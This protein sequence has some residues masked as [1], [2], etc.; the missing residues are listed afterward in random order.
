MTKLTLNQIVAEIKEG[1]EYLIYMK[2]HKQVLIVDADDHTRRLY[3]VVSEYPVLL[4]EIE[5]D[6]DR[7]AARL[8]EGL[9]KVA[10][11]RDV[12]ET[13]SPEVVLEVQERLEHPGAMVKGSP[14]CFV[15][16]IGGKRGRPF[17]LSIRERE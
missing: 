11:L 4:E 15:L 9:D 10:L 2:E 17:E 8:A 12:L 14:E 7:M 16:F 3:K 5:I 6:Y 1:E 13:A